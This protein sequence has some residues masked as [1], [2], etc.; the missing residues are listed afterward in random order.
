MKI[1]VALILIF[2]ILVVA[3]VLDLFLD[4][5]DLIY[6]VLNAVGVK[7]ETKYEESGVAS[8]WTPKNV[9]ITALSLGGGGLAI[10]I[11]IKI[12]TSIREGGGY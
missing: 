2:I 7:V 10:F 12:A 6:R 8:F 5:A 4:V 1:L 11:I 9:A 3:A